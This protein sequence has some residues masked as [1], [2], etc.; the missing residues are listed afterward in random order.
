MTLSDLASKTDSTAKLNSR[1][2]PPS[3]SSIKLNSSGSV[4]RR[5]GLSLSFFYPIVRMAL[6]SI[7]T[8]VKPY[9]TEEEKIVCDGVTWSGSLAGEIFK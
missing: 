3:L 4:K 6:S 1:S 8:S 2:V 5:T 7:E 9:Y